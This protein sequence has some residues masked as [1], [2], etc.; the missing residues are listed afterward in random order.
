MSILTD[1]RWREDPACNKSSRRQEWPDR[2]YVGSI[3]P[4]LP[5]GRPVCVADFL[6]AD[7]WY[8]VPNDS[9]PSK[10]ETASVR[11]WF[12]SEGKGRGVIFDMHYPI[13][14]PPSDAGVS[15]WVCV[16]HFYEHKSVG[17]N[18]L[19]H[20]VVV[21][22]RI[23]LDDY[24]LFSQNVRGARQH[25]WIDAHVMKCWEHIPSATQ[26]RLADY[27]LRN[28]DMLR[29]KGMGS[30]VTFLAEMYRPMRGMGLMTRSVTT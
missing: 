1:V 30:I 9:F 26:E 24:D 8:V 17:P 13:Y 5:S 23:Q 27:V 29:A 4:S 11:R 3:L 22:Q 15:S 19:P 20:A 16:K 10:D 12:R 7:A 2:T 18:R 6:D 21:V 25:Q 14:A 28:V